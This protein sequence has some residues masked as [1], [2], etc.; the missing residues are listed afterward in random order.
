MAYLHFDFDCL[1]FGKQLRHF[2]PSLQSLLS[3][4]K[5]VLKYH[6][7][8]SGIDV[9]SVQL[10]LRSEI[11]HKRVAPL[12]GE[13]SVV[14]CGLLLLVSCDTCDRC[15]QMVERIARRNWQLNHSQS[16]LY[17]IVAVKFTFKAALCWPRLSASDWCFICQ[18]VRHWSV[19][20]PSSPE[21]NFAHA[22]EFVI[23]V[24]H[25]RT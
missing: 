16:K 17:A 6:S 18:R 5:P 13:Q 2:Q 24:S 22:V 11:H 7:R 9:Q 10:R 23:I 15:D 19:L 8:P 1:H 25:N 14:D 21:V 3:E 4:N 20:S 12:H